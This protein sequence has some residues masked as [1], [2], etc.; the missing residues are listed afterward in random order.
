MTSG[1]NAER[2]LR[3]LDETP[4]ASFRQ[5]ARAANLPVSTVHDTVTALVDDG[6]LDRARCSGCGRRV[7]LVPSQEKGA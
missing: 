7:Y 5:L 1:P 6:R 2:I 3:L 4:G